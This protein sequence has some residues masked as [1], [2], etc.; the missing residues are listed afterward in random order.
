MSLFLRDF[1]K[2]IIKLLK[3]RKRNSIKK[4]QMFSYSFLEFIFLSRQELVFLMPVV[5]PNFL[6]KFV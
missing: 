6:S 2:K 5:K 3:I 4:F 1:F